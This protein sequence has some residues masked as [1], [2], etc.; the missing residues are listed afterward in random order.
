M[1]RGL[2]EPVLCREVSDHYEVGMGANVRANLLKA[3][4]M[5]EDLAVNGDLAEK[6]RKVLLS[7]LKLLSEVQDEVVN[8]KSKVR[9]LTYTLRELGELLGLEVNLTSPRLAA[10]DEVLKA[11][12]SSPM[13]EVELEEERAVVKKLI[14][15]Q[16]SA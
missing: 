7:V 13:A 8:A 1:A 10:E 14:S 9:D 3:I 4:S 6:H 5:L 11:L 2:G 16:P 15:A 12:E